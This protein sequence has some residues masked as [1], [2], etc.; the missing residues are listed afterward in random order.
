M[1]LFI[2]ALLAL[3]AVSQ[4]AL[5]A[6]EAD[7]AKLPVVTLTADDT[8]IRE[9]CRITVAPGTVIADANGD[10]VIHVA[11]SNITLVFEPD[12]VLRG[13]APGVLPDSYDGYAIRVADQRN[14]TIR[15]G[16]ISGYRAAV[17]ATHADGLTLEDVDASDNRRQR[18]HSTPAREA[19]Q[20]WM[21][22]HHNDQNEWLL[23][24]AAA[25]YVEDSNEVVVR[26][27][28]VNHGQSALCLDRVTGAKVYDNDF[29][30]NSAWGIA[31]WRT[32]KSII[33]RNACD[34]CIRGYS[35]GVYNRGQ[36][37][38]GIL[39]FEQ[40]NDNVLAENSATH[41]G[42]GFFGYAGREATGEERAEGAAEPPAGERLGCNRN[43]LVKNDF[44]YAAAH[45]I[46]LTFSFGN[47]YI[48]NRL[49]DNSICGIWNGF[50]QDTLIAL[51]EIAENGPMGYGLERG[52]INID[53]SRQNR[54]IGNTF[55]ANRCGVHFWWATDDRFTD[56]AKRHC[57]DWE[58]NL[59][60]DNTFADDEVVLHLRGPG[61]VTLARNNVQ[62]AQRADDI[63][64]RT[65][66]TRD[67]ALEVARPEIPPYPVLG[68]TRPVG[69]R[70][71]LRGRQNI[72]MTE[73][74]PWDHASPL[75]REVENAG[76]QRTY[77]L[78]GLPEAP[79]VEVTGPGVAHLLD[80]VTGGTGGY[81]CTVTAQAPGVY[82]FTLQI[83]AGAFEKTVRGTLVNATWK[84][85]E[86]RWTHDPLEDLDGWR[87]DAERPGYA[88]RKV[89]ALNLQREATRLEGPATAP[90]E[91]GGDDDAARDRRRNRPRVPL[92]LIAETRL[93][94]PAGKWR[95]TLSSG[96]GTRLWAG[97]D[98]KP[99]ID[100]WEARRRGGAL[101]GTLEVATP[102]DVDL[103]IE[104]FR[105]WMPIWLT[106]EIEA[107]E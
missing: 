66:V 47:Q 81:T 41:G 91:A 106:L 13:A 93:H 46:E 89:A 75:V 105:Y 21:Y 90:A 29:S 24:Y 25:F 79:Q 37:S 44:S 17:W 104:Q 73:W 26:R 49:V 58:G 84:L 74:G 15:G 102:R 2:A 98:E 71:K 52:G 68:E 4:S 76:A 5:A 30:F 97:A 88:E 8:V 69:A 62:G 86:F 96:G 27:C 83:R 1:N 63:D 59:I 77:A 67:D 31:L 7:T 82:P 80:P 53:S 23:N 14:V 56:W 107:A 61:K 36:D 48:A 85:R 55:R 95:F 39:M 60:A 99:L 70:P 16:H 101:E 78:E 64:P 72:V 18:L 54:I 28:R 32:N 42:D 3:V 50:S 51:N 12:V 34:F 40:C 94:L 10:G 92:G 100:A 9:S 57:A 20:D 22:P 87:G 6:D 43:L 38:A 33:S 65:N 103:K 11:A 35:H 19:G 45:G